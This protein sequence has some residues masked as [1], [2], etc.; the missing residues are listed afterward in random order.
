MVNMVIGVLMRARAGAYA[1]ARD[2]AGS[3]ATHHDYHVALFSKRCRGA[4]NGAHMMQ[5]MVGD[6]AI[7]P[8]LV[9][10]L[11]MMGGMLDNCGHR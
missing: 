2:E 5:G 7:K 3:K 6:M 8:L 11:G 4:G 9:D 1:Q 10:I